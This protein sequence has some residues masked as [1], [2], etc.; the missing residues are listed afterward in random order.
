MEAGSRAFCQPSENCF[1]ADSGSGCLWHHFIDS[2]YLAGPVPL[3]EHASIGTGLHAGQLRWYCANSISQWIY[4]AKDFFLNK[5]VLPFIRAQGRSLNFLPWQNVGNASMFCDFFFAL[6]SVVQSP[7]SSPPSFRYFPWQT[8]SGALWAMLPGRRSCS[9]KSRRK[10]DRMALI[11]TLGC[12]CSMTLLC[13]Q[14]PPLAR[15]RS[16][17]WVAHCLTLTVLR[18]S[19]WKPAGTRPW[20]RRFW[21]QTMQCSSWRPPATSQQHCRMASW[22]SMPAWRPTSWISPCALSGQWVTNGG[23]WLSDWKGSFSW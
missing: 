4:M 17:S 3:A 18:R 22:A 7:K 6:Q 20:R 12:E 19:C 5:W 9:T 8:R 23:F 1:L 10:L 11:L 2:H 14:L 16:V 15:Q 21:P 13:R